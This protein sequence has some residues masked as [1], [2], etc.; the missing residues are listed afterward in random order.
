M[1]E[2]SSA[3]GRAGKNQI[4]YVVT[5]EFAGDRSMQQAFEDVMEHQIQAKLDEQMGRKT[6]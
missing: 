6:G 1:G 3:Q 4:I 2:R 5:R